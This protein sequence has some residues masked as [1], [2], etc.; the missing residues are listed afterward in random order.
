[1]FL[2][3]KGKRQ[4]A[5]FNRGEGGWRERNVERKASKLK[6]GEK[7]RLPPFSLVIENSDGPGKKTQGSQLENKPKKEKRTEAR[8]SGRSRV[9]FTILTGLLGLC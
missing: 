4:M 3:R 8:A 9:V 6:Q 5:G 7:R 2:L 1:M